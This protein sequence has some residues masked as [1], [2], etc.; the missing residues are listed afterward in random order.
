MAGRLAAGLLCETRIVSVGVRIA[1]MV[2]ECPYIRIKR[3]VRKLR[4]HGMLAVVAG[5]EKAGDLAPSGSDSEIAVQHNELEHALVRG[6]GI[7]GQ[8]VAEMAVAALGVRVARL[9]LYLFGGHDEL[10]IAQ[11]RHAIF[12]RMTLDTFVAGLIARVQ[13]DEQDHECELGHQDDHPAPIAEKLPEF[14][15]SHDKQDTI[16][17]RS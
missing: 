10:R 15:D 3:A 2:Q 11:L 4:K 8:A 1:I 9:F 17:G 5:R 14:T 6:V 13:R 7:I 16:G 12:V